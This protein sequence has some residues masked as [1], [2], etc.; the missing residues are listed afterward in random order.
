MPPDTSPVVD[1]PAHRHVQAGMPD[2]RLLGRGFAVLRIYVGVVLLANGLAKL[3]DFKQI[4][5]GPYSS[6][7]IDRDDAR[8]ILEFEVFGN[9][10]G[11][12]EGTRVWLLR[13][14]TEVMLENWTV[15]GWGL[16]FFEVGVGLLLV[17]GLVTRGAALASLGMHVFLALAY[18]TSNRWMFEQP[19][20]YVPA[21]ILALVPAGR[22]WGLDAKVAGRF[23]R[24]RAGLRE[25]WPF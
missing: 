9:P 18:A 6:F 15:V 23:G 12:A 16:T 19:H 21:L 24:S 20:E 22:V 11:G 17:L 8:G 25:G 7:L 13:D 5:I 2:A 1:R 10:N 14:I 3:F 4:S